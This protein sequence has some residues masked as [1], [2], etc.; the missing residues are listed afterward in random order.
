M[1]TA[2]L[3]QKESGT[4]ISPRCSEKTFACNPGSASAS[5]AA[6]TGAYRAGS[7]D[8]LDPFSCCLWRWGCALYMVDPKTMSILWTR[9]I[10]IKLL[11]AS[12]GMTIAGGLIIRKIVNMEV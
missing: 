5:E 4:A 3:I 11:W 10:G 1:S 7:P 8:R 6:G 12:A 9:D 2:I